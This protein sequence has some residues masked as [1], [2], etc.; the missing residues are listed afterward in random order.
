MKKI[1]INGRFLLHRITGVERYATELIAELDKLVKPGQVE[2]AIPP[3]VTCIP[4][5]KNIIVIQTG[6]LRNLLWEHISFPLY[7]YKQRGISLNLC[8]VAPLVCPGIVCIHD[9]KIKAV[10]EFFKKKFLFWYSLLFLNETRRAKAVITVSKFSKSEICRYYPA[11]AKKIY[12]IPNSWQHFMRINYDEK[13]LEKYYLK[14]EEY[15]FT[16]CSLEPNKNFK[17]IIEAAKKNQDVIFAVAGS[18]NK[19]VFSNMLGFECLPNI[20]LL[21]Y[22][23]DEEA[24]TLMRDCKAFL[25]P[26]FYEGFGIPPLEAA[27]A[28]VKNIVVSDTEIMHEIY[29]DSAIYINP[30]KPPDNFLFSSKKEKLEELLNAYSWEQSAKKLY[31]LIMKQQ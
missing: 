7:V 20:K 9:V 19:T 10:P 11:A 12:V 15:F 2:I 3:E 30:Y 17:W 21:G 16:M 6:K 22:V 23:S 4:E 1:I 31:E 24:K 5:Y 27:S 18:I 29:G 28:G 14:K 25:F 26:T 8:N 13:T